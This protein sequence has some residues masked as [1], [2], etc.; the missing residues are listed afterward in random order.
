MSP[1]DPAAPSPSPSNSRLPQRPLVALPPTATTLLRCERSDGRAVLTILMSDVVVSQTLQVVSTTLGFEPNL[2]LLMQRVGTRTLAAM[3]IAIDLWASG[4]S[5]R[6]TTISAS[7][8]ALGPLVVSCLAPLA[9]TQD[10]EEASQ[11]LQLRTAAFALFGSLALSLMARQ[12]PDLFE[13]VAEVARY[14]GLPLCEVYR[15]VS[16]ESVN[17]A[18]SRLAQ[19]WDL[20]RELSIA[21]SGPGDATLAPHEKAM[22]SALD[23][24]T[25]AAQAAAVSLEPWPY[26]CASGSIVDFAVVQALSMRARRIASK[27]QE[28]LPDIAVAA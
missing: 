1:R 14:R 10:L 5:T 6:S 7:H 20:P 27:L 15:L 26:I 16:G 13:R 12:E 17:V 4:S 9:L 25:T 3:G 22:V 11:E 24:A 8:M 21:L 19:G 28:S 18:A 2:T 23:L